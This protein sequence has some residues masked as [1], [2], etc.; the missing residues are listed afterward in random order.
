MGV[1]Q[2][3]R[4]DS[5]R[6]HHFPSWSHCSPSIA[7]WYRRA[8]HEHQSAFGFGDA[9]AFDSGVIPM[10]NILV[11]GMYVAVRARS[12]R[13]PFSSASRSAASLR[14]P[15]SSPWLG[16]GPTAS[17]SRFALFTGSGRRFPQAACLKFTCSLA[18]RLASCPCSCCWPRL[19]DCWPCCQRSI[20]VKPRFPPAHNRVDFVL[21]IRRVL[22]PQGLRERSRRA[23]FVASKSA[24]SPIV[25]LRSAKGLPQ[26]HRLHCARTSRLNRT[27]SLQPTP[28]CRPSLPRR[29]F[30]NPTGCTP[31]IVLPESHTLASADPPLLPFAPAKGLPQSH[32]LHCARSSRLRNRTHSLQR[33]P[34]CRPS[35]PRRGFPNPTGCTVPDCLA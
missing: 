6:S 8:F 24:S 4:S 35:L 20:V 33:T 3:W 25:A 7:L 18:T 14:S 5:S 21:Y 17:G 16:P 22:S 19:A 27:H 2:S 11:I 23:S 1:S 29:G 10:A 31:S 30:P 28:H 9:P 34:H 26:S 15:P 12:V 32:R 13:V